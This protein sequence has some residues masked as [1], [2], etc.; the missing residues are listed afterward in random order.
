MHRLTGNLVRD[1]QTC[2]LLL[3]LDHSRAGEQ[4]RRIGCLRE[5]VEP[6]LR[7]RRRLTDH[8]IRRLRAERKL[9][10]D[11]PVR[12]ARV[13]RYVQRA[14]GYGTRIRLVV[15]A[16]IAHVRCPAGA[17]GILGRR[18]E[19][20][21]HRLAVA[22]EDAGIVA[23]HAPEVREVENVVGSAD[24]ERVDPVV[25]HEPANAVELRVV[26]GPAHR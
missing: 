11:A 25:R 4:W 23:L 19:T 15:A 1:A 9:Q 18:L 14:P 6:R 22:R 20:D 12:A 17:G 10:P 2:D 16:D 26:A 8:S 13:D 7:E 5:R 24:D 3:G 21:E